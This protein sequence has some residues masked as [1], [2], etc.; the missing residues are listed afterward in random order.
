MKQK[1]IIICGAGGF[2]GGHLTTKLKNQGHW[3][4]GVDLKYNEFHKS[5]ADEFIIAD[6]TEDKNIHKIFSDNID[7][8]YQLAADIGGA[9]YIFTGEHDADIMSNSAKININVAHACIKYN[10]KK[11]FYSSSACM[12]PSY[13]QLDPLNPNCEEK[14]AYPA[15]PDSEYGWEKLFSERLYL[16]FMRNYGLQV[17]IARFHNIFGPNG[18]WVGGK[19]KC[20]AALCRK[21]AMATDSI[22]IIGDGYQTRSFLY[23]D[24]CI[25]GIQRLM[26][27]DFTG[28]VNIGSEEMISI[29]DFAKMV[30]DIS[31]KTLSINHITGPEGVRGRNSCNKLIKEKLGWAPS[32]SLREGME[33]TYKW[34]LNNVQNM[35]SENKNITLIGI[36][37][38]GLCTA[39]CI[40]RAGYNVLGIDI[41]SKY[42]DDLNN[43]TFKTNEPFVEEYLSKSKNFKA[44]MSLQE[45]LDFSDTIF[46]LVDTPLG[47]G[48]NFYDHSKVSNLFSKINN[49]KVSNKNFIICCT[50]MPGYINN[51]AK[52]LLQDCQN[53]TI[54]YNPE[55]IA[56]GNIIRGLENPDIVL[57]GVENDSIKS[58]LE[59][60]YIKLCHNTPVLCSMSPLDAEIVKIATN[61]FITTKISFANLLGDLCDKYGANK[62]IVSNAIGSDS[63]IGNKYFSPGFSFGGPC[64]PR[65]TDAFGLLIKNNNLNNCIIKATRDYNEY[66]VEVQAQT[67]LH[68][69]LDFYVFEDVNYK[70]NCNVVILDES[71]KLKL[72]EYIVKNSSKKVIIYDYPCVISEVKKM[73]GNIFSYK[74]KCI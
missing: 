26:E 30:I 63:R 71:A 36:G 4:R 66:H 39:L 17:R 73:F 28:P 5:D 15:D 33:I 23:I 29:N 7:E 48:R 70:D 32:K 1:R 11:I 38:L 56:Q 25:E 19:E 8:I 6:L 51:I 47:G 12:Y 62:H 14:S 50:V 55:F 40:E 44:S 65:D 16:S 53:V 35:Y 42:V 74:E 9:C 59:N 18:T 57:L 68:Q 31:G 69:N 37:R 41:N 54:N 49:I 3:V 27:S 72:A 24:E 60:L 64:F 58:T 43:K 21:V 10:I 52:P 34:I 22:D 45:G 46:I 20:P 61:S 67:L 2:I 13:N